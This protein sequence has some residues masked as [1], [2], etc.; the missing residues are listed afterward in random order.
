MAVST[1]VT[2]QGKAIV[3]AR[4]KGTGS[5]P[6]YVGFGTGGASRTANAADTSSS[7]T[8]SGSR[9]LGTSTIVTTTVTNDTHR[10]SAT[11][12]NSTGSSLTINEIMLFDASTSGNSSVSAVTAGSVLNANDSLTAIISQKMG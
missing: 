7:I 12:T 6:L 4:L 10:V 5:E 11:F 9:V 1:V 2:N 3:A 8:Q